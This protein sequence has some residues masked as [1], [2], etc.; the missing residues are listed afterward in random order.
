VWDANLSSRIITLMAEIW[1][2]RCESFHAEAEADAEFWLQMTPAERVALVEQMRREWRERN[3]GSD[4]GLRR[5]AR[6]FST[7]QS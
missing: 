2:R 5:T 4:E 1:L 6:V 3:G 7:T